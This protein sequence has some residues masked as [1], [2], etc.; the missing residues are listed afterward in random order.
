MERI[1]VFIN[2]AAHARHLLQPMIGAAGSTHWI[3]VACPPTLT[4]HIGRWVSHAARQAWRQRWG[5]ELLAQLAPELA[6]RTGSQVE[7]MVAS[8]P[9]TDVS[10]RLAARLPDVRLLD[11]RRPTLGKPHEPLTTMQPPEGGRRW[12]GTVA[13]AGGFT[14]ML[15]L[16][17]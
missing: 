9:L 17:D 1:A 8:R 15:A 7:R 12:A 4:R 16:A 10:A 6:A 5:E 13:M 14:A 2:D 3:L 11:A